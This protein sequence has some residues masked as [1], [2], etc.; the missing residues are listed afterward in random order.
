MFPVVLVFSSKPCVL[1]V[2]T[3]L[4]VPKIFQTPISAYMILSTTLQ[5]IDRIHISNTDTGTCHAALPLSRS[6]QKYHGG[7]ARN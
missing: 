3:I 7:V 1:S 4:L 5:Q 6:C 2:C